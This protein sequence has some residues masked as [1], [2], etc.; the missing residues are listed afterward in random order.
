MNLLRADEVAQRLRVS[1]ATVYNM[2][3]EGKIPHVKFGPKAIRFPEPEIE[4][5]LAEHVH[6]PPCTN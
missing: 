3:N 6:R 2:A 4:A 1:R 5:W